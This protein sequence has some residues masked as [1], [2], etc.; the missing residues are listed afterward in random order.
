MKHVSDDWVVY[1]MS[2]ANYERYLR[3][4]IKSEDVRARD[5]GKFVCL[6]DTYI[7][8]DD[9]KDILDR[10]K[11]ELTRELVKKAEKKNPNMTAE[12][13]DKIYDRV[14]KMINKFNEE[15]VI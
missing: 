14:V 8:Y 5:Y 4:S 10:F 9:R 13:K 11:Y 15:E 3:D 12:Q 6:I 1:K 7:G 2:N